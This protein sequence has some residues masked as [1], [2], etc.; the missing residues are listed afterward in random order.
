MLTIP[1]RYGKLHIYLTQRGVNETMSGFR[2][3]A[4]F[5]AGYSTYLQNFSYISFQNYKLRF[6]LALY[7]YSHIG[8]T[9]NE[10]ATALGIS[11]M[12]LSRALS[13]DVYVREEWEPR[14][15]EIF[16][17]LYTEEFTTQAERFACDKIPLDITARRYALSHAAMEYIAQDKKLDYCV[18]E[19]Y[20]GSTSFC[21]CTQD[22]QERWLFLDY[23]NLNNHS[24]IAQYPLPFEELNVLCDNNNITRVTLFTASN[25]IFEQL[26]GKYMIL[27]GKDNHANPNR[28]CSIMLLTE[29]DL[30]LHKEYILSTSSIDSSNP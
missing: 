4:D 1:Y 10:F 13:N 23:D 8:G 7:I 9:Q 26:I 18:L 19:G 22:D 2:L 17:N 12:T 16:A 28:Y 5:F 27:L 15:K 30:D 14:I 3:S 6:I 11:P 29:L 24:D 20:D 25:S 21:L